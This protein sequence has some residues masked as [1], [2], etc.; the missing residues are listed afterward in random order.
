MFGFIGYKTTS[1]ALDALKYFNNSYLDTSKLV[2][3][4]ARSVGPSR[5]R[6]AEPRAKHMVA[7]AQL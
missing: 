2:V 1:E 5:H 3:E 7:L 4:L 6:A